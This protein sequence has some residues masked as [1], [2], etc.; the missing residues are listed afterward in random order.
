MQSIY[1]EFLQY[2]VILRAVKL[3]IT[4]IVNSFSYDYQ[5]IIETISKNNVNT[6]C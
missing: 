4:F 6:C 5:I 2:D 1:I 3:N